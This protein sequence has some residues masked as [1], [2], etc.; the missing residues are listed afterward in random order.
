M[1]LLGNFY[2]SSNG[3]ED[4]AYKILDKLDKA[5]W[6]YYINECFPYDEDVLT[7]IAAGDRRTQVWCRIVKKYNLL[8]LEISDIKLQDLMKASSNED[9]NNAKAL[10]NN[11]LRIYMK[12]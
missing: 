10:A 6:K 12:R 8:D 1:V 4:T 11:I 7:K 2:G 9:K 5:S 3:A